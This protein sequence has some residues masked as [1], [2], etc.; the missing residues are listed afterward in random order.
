MGP[1]FR[2]RDLGLSGDMARSQHDPFNYF[3]RLAIALFKM[4]AARQAWPGTWNAVASLPIMP[5]WRV[6]L[7][8]VMYEKSFVGRSRSS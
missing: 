2:K 3:L 5:S 4:R 6:V 7:S 1:G 8:E